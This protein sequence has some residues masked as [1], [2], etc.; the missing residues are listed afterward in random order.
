MLARAQHV[1]P[2]NIECKGGK[3]EKKKDRLAPSKE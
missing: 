2:E 1:F 3:N